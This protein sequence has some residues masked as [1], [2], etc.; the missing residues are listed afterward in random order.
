M[1][2]R[3]C[4]LGIVVLYGILRETIAKKISTANPRK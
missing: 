4:R 1:P 3:L 2:K